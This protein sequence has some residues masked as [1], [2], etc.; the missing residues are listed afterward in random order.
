MIYMSSAVGLIHDGSSTA[1]RT[2]DLYSHNI[3]T[4]TH[5][6]FKLDS[7]ILANLKYQIYY[8]CFTYIKECTGLWEH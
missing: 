6:K 8:S 7:F 1:H 3:H 2:G 4:H 5:T